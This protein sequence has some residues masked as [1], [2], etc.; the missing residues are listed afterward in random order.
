MKKKKIRCL[1]N[2]AIIVELW[3]TLSSLTKWPFCST[4]FLK[5]CSWGQ[6]EAFCWVHYVLFCFKKGAIFQPTWFK[7]KK[8]SYPASLSQSKCT[9]IFIYIL[10]II[11]AV[12]EWNIWIKW[13]VDCGVKEIYRNYRP[14]AQKW[15][16]AFSW[17]LKRV[18]F[19]HR[20][21]YSYLK[22]VNN[23]IFD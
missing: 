13:F 21:F 11:I 2:E 1:Q 17:I 4:N 23:L 22:H 14:K 5:R 3:Q 10:F 12:M 18:L 20:S 16:Q 6:I 19:T 15:Q 9:E 7:K 8:K